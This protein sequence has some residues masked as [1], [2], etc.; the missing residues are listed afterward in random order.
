M[1][2]S[3]SALSMGS[4]SPRAVVSALY[5][6]LWAAH[7]EGWLLRKC[8]TQRAVRLSKRCTDS[9]IWSALHIVSGGLSAA[10]APSR[11][12][13]AKSVTFSRTLCIRAVRWSLGVWDKLWIKALSHLMDG[14]RVDGSSKDACE[15]LFAQL[16]RG[17]TLVRS[18]LEI[19]KRR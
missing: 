14:V 16:R 17:R 7:R 5:R 12:S 19:Q 18:S 6:A 4:L 10:H 8:V 3:I 11:R 13:D 1:T 15:L 9:D 2:E